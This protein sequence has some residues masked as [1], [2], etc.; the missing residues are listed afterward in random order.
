[1]GPDNIYVDRPDD[2]RHVL[3]ELVSTKQNHRGERL[4]AG[5]GENRT[6]DSNRGGMSQMKD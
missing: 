1:M 3:R 4:P 6:D 5:C 2:I